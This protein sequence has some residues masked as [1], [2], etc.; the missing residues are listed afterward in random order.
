MVEKPLEV[1]LA[2]CDALIDACRR[3]GVLLGAIFQSRFC[4][5]A[6]RL[7][8]AVDAN[9]FGALALGS[10]RIQWFREQEY[11]DKGAWRGTWELDGGGA[12][13]NQGIHTIDL[14]QWIMG[15]VESVSAWTA[16]R[17]HERIEVED[18]AVAALRFSGGA[19]GTID[20]TTSSWPGW[21]RR[22]EICGA[23]GSAVLEGDE[24]ARWN[25][26]TDVEESGPAR[27]PAPSGPGTGGATDPASISIAGHTAQL[28]DFVDAIESGGQ[29]AIDGAEARRSVALILAIYQSACEGRPVKPDSPA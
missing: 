14:L 27:S 25:L 12:L 11:Y 24:L 16:T 15:T 13:M 28:Q 5:P 3:A 17:S 18:T 20:A 26:S 1:T 6:L 19:L 2:R 9:R 22:L 10:A 23:T 7:K 29:P 8:Q 21:S 4:E